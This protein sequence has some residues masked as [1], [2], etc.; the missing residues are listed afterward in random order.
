MPLL[1]FVLNVDKAEVLLAKFAANG[2][3]E[4]ELVDV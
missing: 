2:Q 1:E 4:G 3:R